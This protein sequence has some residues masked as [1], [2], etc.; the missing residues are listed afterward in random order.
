[1]TKNVW[2]VNYSFN[3]HIIKDIIITKLNLCIVKH[4]IVRL[5]LNYFVKT[6][7]FIFVK[8]FITICGDE[9]ILFVSGKFDTLED[10]S[11]I[12]IC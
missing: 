1:M 5:S 7:S 12:R 6:K 8:Y 10:S 11:V 2:I 4:V 9:I 3:V